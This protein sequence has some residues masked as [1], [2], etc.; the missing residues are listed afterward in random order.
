MNDLQ[1]A[2]EEKKWNWLSSD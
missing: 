2:L 1:I